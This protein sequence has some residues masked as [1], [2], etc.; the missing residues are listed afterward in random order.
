MT[1]DSIA[2]IVGIAGVA[3]VAG[4]GKDTAASQ[5]EAEALARGMS[6]MRLSFMEPVR[7]MLEALG[8]PPRY[9]VERALKEAPVP[10]IGRS[11]RQLAQS[12]GSE[13]GRE[14]VDR[15]LWMN[16][17]ARRIDERASTISP[18]PLIAIVSDVRLADE[19]NWVR[20]QGGVL[21]RV[22]RADAT[23]VATHSTE[24]QAGAPS[25]DIDLPNDTSLEAFERRVR[26]L[27]SSIFNLAAARKA[28]AISIA[29]SS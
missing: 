6:S 10:G 11:Y 13:W 15:D 5:L 19:A 7:A 29:H 22:T 27:A 26:A 8:V 14:L 23:A 12:L 1:A 28:P 4:V 2:M 25:V 16:V 21:L 9:M 18:T 17:A 24:Q 3:G 20:S